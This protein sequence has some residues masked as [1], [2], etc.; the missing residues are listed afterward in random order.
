MIVLCQCMKHDIYLIVYVIL[1]I[2][3]MLILPSLTLINS[4][5]KIEISNNLYIPYIY[6]N[7]TITSFQ[8]SLTQTYCHNF[9]DARKILDIILIKELTDIIIQYADNLVKIGIK[10]GNRLRKSDEITVIFD[11]KIY[12]YNNTFLT[13]R[14][15]MSFKKVHVDFSDSFHH[16]NFMHMYNNR[17]YVDTGYNKIIH[18]FDNKLSGQ[19]TYANN[20]CITGKLIG[21]SDDKIFTIYVHRIDIW[22]MDGTKIDS[23]YIEDAD[24][25]LL[26]GY[27][28]MYNNNI[29]ICDKKKDCV[30]LYTYST[31]GKLITKRNYGYYDYKKFIN[32]YIS[33]KYM[34]LV[35]S[36][37]YFVTKYELDT[38]DKITCSFEAAYNENFLVDIRYNNG[39]VYVFYKKSNDVLYM[40]T[41]EI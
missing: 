29:Y 31:E 4:H 5:Q 41:H 17:I 35:D 37:Y 2:Y 8:M 16:E 3:L 32:F 23:F 9:N 36:M 14:P 25:A 28:R 38:G 11:D 21:I 22:T 33:E 15:L 27:V 6:F 39:K 24:K 34:Y 26:N 30:M 13:I 40:F 20:I 10:S 7:H 12:T 1:I 18:V 19:C